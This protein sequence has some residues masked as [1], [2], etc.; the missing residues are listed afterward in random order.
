MHGITTICFLNKANHKSLVINF[1][2]FTT[3]L[4]SSGLKKT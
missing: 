2:P 1:A 3:D 4:L